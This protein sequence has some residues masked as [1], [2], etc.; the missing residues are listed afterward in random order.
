[1]DVIGTLLYRFVQDFMVVLLL[2][3][4][5]RVIVIILGVFKDGVVT[6]VIRPVPLVVTP[7]LTTVTYNLVTLAMV[8]NQYLV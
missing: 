6:L 7:V 5:V 8:L 4:M 1:V 3:E 2:V